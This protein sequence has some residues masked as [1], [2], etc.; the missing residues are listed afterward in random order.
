MEGDLSVTI[1][2]SA[3]FEAARET[4]DGNFAV[5]AVLVNREDEMGLGSALEELRDVPKLA[6][7]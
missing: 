3:V 1:K 4:F 5:L 2:T 7:L 6:I